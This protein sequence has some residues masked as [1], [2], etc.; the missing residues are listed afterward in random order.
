MIISGSAFIGSLLLTGAVVLLIQK[1]NH[2]K[3]F[4]GVDPFANTTSQGLQAQINLFGLQIGGQMSTTLTW[5][6]ALLMLGVALFILHSVLPIL[7]QCGRLNK[8]IKEMTG[9]SDTKDKDH[10][11]KEEE[12][13][14]LHEDIEAHEDTNKE[15]NNILKRNSS[16]HKD[17]CEL[18]HWRHNPFRNR[19]PSPAPPPSY[20]YSAKDEEITN[21]DSE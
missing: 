1:V 20:F 9:S 10:E 16:F 6:L 19:T 15:T 13:L 11:I 2:G 3:I 18:T 14:E 4:G 17:R 8:E 21:I 5:F 7:K 12:E